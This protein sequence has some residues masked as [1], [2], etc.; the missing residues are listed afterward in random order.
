ML[1]FATTLPLA[2]AARVF[3]GIGDATAFTAALRLVPYWF[4]VRQVP[5]MTQLTG[6]LGLIGQIISSFP[7]AWVL[8]GA[9]SGHPR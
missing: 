1:A 2:L 3:I 6:I 7:F 8:T 5:L 9:G 4:P